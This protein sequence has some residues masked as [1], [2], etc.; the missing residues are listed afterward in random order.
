MAE[1]G[2]NHSVCLSAWQGCSHYSTKFFFFFWW[3][4]SFE[5]VLV[6]DPENSMQ[7]PWSVPFG[8]LVLITILFCVSLTLNIGLFIS[9]FHFGDF[10]VYIPVF[11][12]Y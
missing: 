4:R 7:R 1:D 10:P 3:G 12:G 8:M 9:E 2:R 5:L 11:T 6:R